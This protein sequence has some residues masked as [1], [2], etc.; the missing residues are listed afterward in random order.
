MALWVIFLAGIEALALPVLAAVA[1]VA[2]FRRKPVDVGLGPEALINN[3]YHRRALLARGYSAETFVSAV[4]FITGQFD[5]RGDRMFTWLPGRVLRA[6][7]VALWFAVRV[8][9]RYRVLYISFN[10]GPL[11]SGAIWLDRLE[12]RLLRI[13]RVRT[14]ILPY[15][16]DVQD[17]QLSPNLAFKHA[18]S[19]DYPADRKRIAR[20]KRQVRRWTQ[21]ADHLI[22][23]CEWVDYMGHWDTLM[24]AHF[25]IDTAWW[26]PA[27]S[28][29]RGDGPLRI[30]H[31]PNHRTIKGTRCFVASVEALRAEGV[32]VELQLL[33]RV[34]NDQVRAAIRAVDVVADQLIVGWY[35]MF[36]LEGM[37]M[38]KPVLCHLRPDL[39]AL[40]EREGLV[41]PGEIPIIECTPENV[42]EVVRDL[43]ARRG[44]LREIGR[45]SR[46]F[47]IRHHSIDAI[48]AVFERINRRLGVAPADRR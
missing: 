38:E 41:A 16:S 26:T 43:V 48:G 1:V 46:E 8:M 19:Q 47:A 29:P 33:E 42:K 44:E 10:G 40:Y 39:K 20:V 35:A 6:H 34:P 5:V 7:A 21:H 32:P 11:G 14:L 9:W 27:E 18:K 30:L 15:G 25:S 3:I 24:L 31:A 37:A 4:S 12:P 23:G 17:M 2:R 13:A 36:A 45:R 28:A 22:G